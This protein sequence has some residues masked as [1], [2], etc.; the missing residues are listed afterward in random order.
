MQEAS[1]V[2]FLLLRLSNLRSRWVQTLDFCFPLQTTYETYF[3][4]GMST[5]FGPLG[6][7]DYTEIR[8]ADNAAVNTYM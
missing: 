1:V 4:Y 6:S 5:K 7:R 2:F 8:T 3:Q